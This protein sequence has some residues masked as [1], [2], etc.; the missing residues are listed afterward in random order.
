MGP[1][2]GGFR[3]DARYL[4]ELLQL[5]LSNRDEGSRLFAGSRTGGSQRESSLLTNYWSES[6]SSSR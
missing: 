4:F 6:T 2:F 5:S 3:D 1:S